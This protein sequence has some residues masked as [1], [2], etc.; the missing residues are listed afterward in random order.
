MTIEHIDFYRARR[1]KPGKGARKALLLQTFWQV[2]N[3]ITHY[4]IAGAAG[5]KDAPE[6]RGRAEAE[7]LLIA[8]EL[9]NITKDSQ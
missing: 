6:Q 8:T 5:S 2:N 3:L 4:I 9:L 1:A 7:R